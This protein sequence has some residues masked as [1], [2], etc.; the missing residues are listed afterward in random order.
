MTSDTTYD[1]IEMDH[2]KPVCMFDLTT[3]EEFW[4]VFSWKITQ[5]LLQND[6]QQKRT[7]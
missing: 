6:H 5:P 4:D 1:K 7:K 3:E 2:V